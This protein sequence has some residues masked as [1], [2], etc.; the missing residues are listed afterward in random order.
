MSSPEEKKKRKR[1]STTKKK[2]PP[3]VLTPTATQSTPNPSLPDDL[4]LSCFAR[5]SR[6][7]YPTLSLVSK[8][9]QSLLAS[10]ELYKTRSSIGRTESCLYVCLLSHPDPIPRWYTL[11]RKPDKTLTTNEDTKKLKKKSSGYVLAKIPT[12]HSGPVHWSGLA[13][14]GSDIYNIGGLINDDKDPSSRVLIMDSRSNRWREGPSMLVKR[15]YPVTSVLDGK[16]YVA[17]GCKGCSSSSEWMEV[18]DPK[19]QSW[20]LVSSPGTEIC[21][22]NYVSKRAGF[23]GKVY[24]F[25]GG[26]GL[27]YKPREGRWERVGWEMDTSWP[28]YSYAVIDNVLYQYNGGFKWYDTNARVWKGLKGVKGLPNFPRYIARLAD[29]GGKMAV[30]WERVLA[31]TGFKDK[32]IL[33]AVIALERRNSE[34]IWGKV[35]WHDTVLT[36]SKSCRVDYAL[37]TTV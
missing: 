8:T 35:E 28:W 13:T 3:L 21:G 25:G 7:Y 14:V 34:E 32:M 16:I 6:L 12:S 19:N 5:V 9:F 18:F 26:N 36:V 2:K 29:Y 22:C 4:L 33:C 37:A 11:C 15:R 24:M 10:P 27:A 31:S 17:G 1:M 23:D 20:E 30:L